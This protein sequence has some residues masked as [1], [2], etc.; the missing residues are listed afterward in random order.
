MH[1]SVA[2]TASNESV[3]LRRAALRTATV[4]TLAVGCIVLVLVGVL[5]RRPLLGLAAGACVGATT[6]TAEFL[7][8]VVIERPPTPGEVAQ[9]SHNSFPSGHVAISTS[10]ALAAMI[11]V[12]H[13]WR[14]PVGAIAA[15]WVT[16]QAAGVL[17]AGWHRPSD[18]L[19]GYAIALAWAALAVWALARIGRV[20]PSVT[21][22]DSPA[23]MAVV[24]LCTLVV[25][26]SGLAIAAFGG[27]SVSTQDR[28]PLVVANAVIDVAGVAVVGWFW[29]LLHGWT[30]GHAADG[31]GL[32]DHAIDATVTR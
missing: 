18:A 21:S 20:S 16:F 5:R 22:T 31:S 6:L 14:R 23:T 32:E 24:L 17:A 12:P 7:K 15:L 28:V 29:R 25:A 13:R 4:T 11:V 2:R 10:L 3:P 30:I 27:R 26:L 19:G 9:L 8:R 1:L